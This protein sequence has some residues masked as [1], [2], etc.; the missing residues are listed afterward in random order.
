MQ[1]NTPVPVATCVPPLCDGSTTVVLTGLVMGAR[2]R[3]LADGAELGLA[4]SPVDG[5]YDF[6]VPALVGGGMITASQE[7]CGE[8]SPPA[9]SAGRQGRPS[10]VPTPKLHEP[11]Y[12]CGA[13]VRV[14]NLHLGARVYVYSALLG[15]PI[16]ERPPMPSEVD[17]PVAPLLIAGDTIFAVQRGCGLVSSKSDAV[18]RRR[19]SN[20]CRRRRVVEPLYS[21]EA[22]VRVV[23]VVPGAR[24]DV[25]VDGIFRGSAIGGGTDLTVGV[26]GELEVGDPVTALQRLCEHTSRLSKPVIVQEFLRPLVSGRRQH[27]GGILAVHAALLHT[28]K[29]V[30][31][32]GDQHD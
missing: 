26:S 7:L 5:T 19:K 27:G 11:L 31:F 24:V 21:C 6:L 12:E 28:G 10:A 30:Y 20:G 1:D 2:V 32:G 3:I 9:R 29:I 18:D 15:V 25:Y 23:N 8:W 16:G 22:A 17:V 13:A 14:S 4:E